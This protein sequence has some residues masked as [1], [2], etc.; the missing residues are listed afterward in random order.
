MADISVPR[1]PSQF[2][3]LDTSAFSIAVAVARA[4]NIKVDRRCLGMNVRDTYKN[5][6]G[7]KIQTKGLQVY[8]IA[9]G[10]MSHGDCP[11]PHYSLNIVFD[12]EGT[13]LLSDVLD[14]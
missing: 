7:A 10:R 13:F 14:S 6:M 9:F 1:D 4:H 3:K 12:A 11:D 8:N 5:W 2:S